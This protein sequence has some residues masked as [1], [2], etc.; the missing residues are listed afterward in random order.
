MRR[1]LYFMLPDIN[2]A[3]K[4]EEELL[5]AHID[6]HHMH[7]LATMDT[8]LGDL[9]KANVLQRTDLLHGMFVGSVAGGLTGAAVGTLL[10]LYPAFGASLGMGPI[11][12]L[13]IAG[14]IF[15][16]WASG[17][18]AISTPNSRLKAFHQM[19]NK[20]NILLM[21]DAPKERV[22]EITRMIKQHHPEADDKGIEAHI[23]A[24][25]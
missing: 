5:L 6:D 11:L 1:R 24:F 22:D 23:P 14:I 4:I 16:S 19:I 18:I 15:G 20:G 10:Y 8:K 9:P 2:T 12:G 25:P 13:A 17:M 21:V 3:K 7:F